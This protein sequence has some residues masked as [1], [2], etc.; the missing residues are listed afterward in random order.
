MSKSLN[1]SLERRLLFPFR[2]FT[3]FASFLTEA[4][5]VK[6]C[7]ERVGFF[8]GCQSLAQIRRQPFERGECSFELY[9]SLLVAHS[10][11]SRCA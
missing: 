5:S 6:L 1:V 9:M 8:K 10:D 7:Q 4:F 11:A 3:A 2:M